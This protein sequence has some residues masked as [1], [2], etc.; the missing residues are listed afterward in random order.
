MISSQ[1]RQRDMSVARTLFMVVATDFCCWF[2]I[3]VMG[4]LSKSGYNIPDDA[5]AWIMVFVLPVNAAINPFLYTATAIWRKRQR[6]KRR[7]E[8][9]SPNRGHRHQAGAI[10]METPMQ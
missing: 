7:V 1:T 8:M 5:Y 6:E 4:V 9:I 10:E 2:P 3:G